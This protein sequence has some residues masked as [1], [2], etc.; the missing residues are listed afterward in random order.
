MCFMTSRRNPFAS[1]NATVYRTVFL[2]FNEIQ[3]VPYNKTLNR[4]G[5]NV[6]RSLLINVNCPPG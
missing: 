5:N 4:S 1:T 3:T 2:R 6:V